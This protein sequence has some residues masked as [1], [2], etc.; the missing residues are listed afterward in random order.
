MKRWFIL[1]KPGLFVCGM[2]VSAMM[3][4]ECGS[5]SNP[6]NPVALPAPAL[7]SPVE[8]AMNETTALTLAWSSSSGAVSYTVQISTASSFA[9]VFSSQTSLTALSTSVSSLANNTTYYWKVS[10]TNGTETS[11]W[12][13]VWCFTTVPLPAP[14]LT[15]PNG[16]TVIPAALSWGGVPGAT[17][18]TVQVATASTFATTVFTAS[19]STTTMVVDSLN[20]DQTYFWRVNAGNSAGAS[21]WSIAWSFFIVSG[22]PAVPAQGSYN[23][24]DPAVLSWNSAAGAS[25]YA[26]QVSDDYYF[27]TTT[28]SQSG[29]TGTSFTLPA[30]IGGGYWEVNASNVCGTSAW[31]SVWSFTESMCKSREVVGVVASADSSGKNDVQLPVTLSWIYYPGCGSSSGQAR[32]TLQIATDSGFASLVV[33]TSSFTITGVAGYWWNY[34]YTTDSLNNGTTYYWRIRQGLGPWSSIYPFTIV[35]APPVLTQPSNNAQNPNPSLSLSWSSV[36]GAAIYQIQLSTAA[37]FS[38]AVFTSN[39]QTGTVYTA[40]PLINNTVYYWH[41]ADSGT[42]AW[43]AWSSVWSF[44]EMW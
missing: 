34:S 5:K 1:T 43:S 31:S 9:S 11:A 17:T 41:A 7:A 39:S 30:N 25:S 21:L 29:I 35:T 3:I 14:V 27:S 38:G 23:N 12:S 18:Y 4:G 36:T 16:S 44:T 33:N 42:G 15:A 8:G 26:F 22:P 37:N 40:G 6:A 10:A 28:F 2:A 13:M 19:G 20:I 24:S 32:Y